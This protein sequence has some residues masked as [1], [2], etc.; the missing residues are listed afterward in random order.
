[1]KLKTYVLTLLLVL[2]LT[3][4]AFAAPPDPFTQQGG[5]NSGPGGYSGVVSSG[6]TGQVAYYAATG[7]TVFGNPCMTFINGKMQLGCPVFGGS[8]ALSGATSG[9]VTITACPTAGN[10]V[11][12]LPC[13][14]GTNGWVLTTNGAGI[15]SWQ[16]GGPG[17]GGVNP[18]L[19][20]QVAWYTVN[21]S[22]VSGNANAT[23]SSGVLTLGQSGT[24]GKMVLNG[25][26]SGTATI[27]VPAVAGTTTFQLPPSTTPALGFLQNDLGASGATSWQAPWNNGAGNVVLSG[28][29]PPVSVHAANIT[30]TSDTG[31]LGGTTMTATGTITIDHQL[32]TFESGF[33]GGYCDTSQ[34]LYVGGGP[35]AGYN[36]IAP[37]GLA[38]GNGG[39]SYGYGGTGGNNTYTHQGSGNFNNLGH[40]TF[41]PG[42]AGSAGMM[43]AGFTSIG[44]DGAGTLRLLAVGT[45]TVDGAIN[46]SVR[47]DGDFGITAPEAT[48]ITIGGTVTPGDTIT[49]IFTNP[50]I[51]GNP[52]SVPYTT[53]GGDDTTTTATALTSLINA[54]SPLTNAN[55]T[56]TSSTN[57]ITV[58]SLDYAI[59]TFSFTL[60]G[61]ATETVTIGT[62]T[63]NGTGSGGG[64][65]GVTGMYSQTGISYINGA[66]T[67]AA[68]GN[69]GNSVGFAA[70]GGGGGGA[71]LLIAPIIT[72]TVLDESPGGSG[73][74]TSTGNLGTSGADA[75]IIDTPTL[76]LISMAEKDLPAIVQMGD[77]QHIAKGIDNRHFAL[78][79]KGEARTY[80]AAY[81]AKDM[82]DFDRLCYW[83]ETSDSLFDET[84]TVQQAGTITLEGIGD[85]V[86][87]PGGS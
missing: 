84:A 29:P 7:T 66:G 22:V 45:I 14:N 68:G 39:G 23:M 42:S 48:D 70:G 6:Q 2:G 33:Q 46:G 30:M 73:T 59:T 52:I 9:T 15:T 4:P 63:D 69:G 47:N 31:F 26:T 10:T 13:T 85:C 36:P 54:S 81:E 17:G 86:G 53:I 12:Q 72:G 32:N 20:G 41:T 60:S 71:Q 55:I 64:G 76:P 35:C 61:G 77:A 21:G 11:F 83:L 5:N 82:K 57:V 18:G 28:T 87:V 43:N 49:L 80:L 62:T 78:K 40:I 3:V 34:I 19:A 51:T 8:L 74:G 58:N 75:S 67:T 65:G 16:P 38:G 1:M 50:D 25:A 37:S 56:A 24:A 44:G 79:G 27:Q